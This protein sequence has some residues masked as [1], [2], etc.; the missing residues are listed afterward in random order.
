MKKSFLIARIVLLLLACLLFG[1]G[2]ESETS[3]GEIGV[4]YDEEFGNIYIDLSIEEFND[5]GFAFGDSVDIRF[6]N[7]VTLEDIPYYSGYYTPVGELLACG[8]QAIPT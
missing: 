4:V 6:D 3:T 1:C 8:Y 5:L 7:G 2:R